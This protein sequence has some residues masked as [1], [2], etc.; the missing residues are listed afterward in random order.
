MNSYET[1]QRLVAAK[2]A[3]VSTNGYLDTFKYARRVM[4]DYLWDTDARLAEC[5][6]HTYDNRTGE[7]VVAAPRKSF[8]YLENGWWKGVS[9]DTPVIAYKKYNGF[10]ACVSK[11]EG[12]VI[13]S[14]T[15]ST[16][17]DF[18]RY[19]KESIGSELKWISDNETL[20]YEIVHA[21]D[22]HIVDEP[23]GAHY[24]GF[25]SKVDG[26]FNPYGKSEDIYVGTL[27]GILAIA[28]VNRGEGFMVY[29]LH[30]D[31]ERLKPAKV[32]TP[33]YVGKKRLMRLS[34]KNSEIMYNDPEKF[35]STL[36]EMWR[37]VPKIITKMYPHNGWNILP[38]QSRR[39]TLE[40]LKGK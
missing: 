40:M 25:R 10:M 18:V 17:S 9:L 39:A 21:D 11:H 22:P 30:N 31:P 2:L 38:E 14:T 35:A 36:P 28:M 16:K 23:V 26:G 3:T 27:K 33:Y 29:D 4:F 24:L 20:L 7:L 8:N 12:E 19:A 32:K 15:G 13:V 6:G 1:M 37:D 5:R 34:S